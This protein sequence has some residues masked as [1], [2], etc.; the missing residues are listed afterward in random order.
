MT[1]SINRAVIDFLSSTHYDAVSTTAGLAAA[2]ALVLLLVQRESVRAHGGERARRWIHGLDLAV[3]PEMAVTGELSGDVVG[4]SV[5]FEGPVRE[6]FARK[7]REHR[8]YIVVPTYL[9]EDGRSGPARL[10]RL[11][12]KK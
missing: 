6:T 2:L 4:H 3:L 8:C 10:L 5:P 7:A 9:L 1:S 12:P 11:E